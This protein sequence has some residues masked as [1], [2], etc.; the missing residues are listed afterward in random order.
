MLGT[1][2]LSQPELRGH[3]SEPLL[4]Q[5]PQEQSVPSADWRFAPLGRVFTSDML[6]GDARAA[7][8]RAAFEEQVLK[9]ESDH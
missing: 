3:L 4:A 1:A 9:V 7:G 5:R 2:C 6:P 8:P